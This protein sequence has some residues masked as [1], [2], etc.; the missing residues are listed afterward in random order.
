MPENVGLTL[1]CFSAQALFIET[2]PII[3]TIRIGF[4]GVVSCD[5]PD[6]RGHGGACKHIHG[7]FIILEDLR[8]QRI[9]IPPIPIPQ[10]LAEAQALQAQVILTITIPPQKSELPTARAAEHLEDI[11]RADISCVQ[12]R[13]DDL[14]EDAA[15]DDDGNASVGNDDSSDSEL[16][17]SDDSP[18]VSRLFA[19]NFNLLADQTY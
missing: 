13:D 12:N 15:G 11:V 18:V 19:M 17:D 4:N 8:H 14:D 9:G 2:D 16:S 6:F 3:Y 7:A 5:C 10:S 1:T